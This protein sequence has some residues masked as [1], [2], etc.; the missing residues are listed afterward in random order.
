[1]RRIHVSIAAA[2]FA[3][4]AGVAGLAQAQDPATQG[5]P[6]PQQAPAQGPVSDEQIESFATALQSVGEI[7]SEYS[8][9]LAEAQEPEAQQQVQMEAQTKMLQAVEAE[10]LTA[11]EYNSLAQRMD[12]DPELQQ[13]VQAELE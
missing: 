7:Q 1:M 12:S 4:G 11:A 6:P 9:K 10:G 5:A 13:R 3:F 8:A 2:A